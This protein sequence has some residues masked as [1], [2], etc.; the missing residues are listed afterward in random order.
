MEK[1][2]KIL[3]E[4][5]EL[6]KVVAEL[7]REA[8][9]EAALE[10]VRARGLAMHHSSELHGVINTVAGQFLNLNIDISG[11]AFICIN[12]EIDNKIIVYGAG[13]TADYA[14]KVTVPFFDRP[15]YTDII[16]RVKNGPG[17]FTEEF[18]KKEKIDFFKHMFKYPPYNQ[19][20]EEHRKKVLAREGGYTRACTVNQHTTIFMVN[21]HGRHFSEADNNI[22]I[23]FGK[24]FEQTYTR[25]LDLQKAETQAREA[26][27]EAALERIRTKTMAMQKSDELRATS[28]LLFNELK[29]L[30]KISTQIS[31]GIFDEEN[32]VLKLYATH[33]GKQ[34]EESSNIDLDEPHAMQKIYGGWKKKKPSIQIDL[35]GEELKAY[36]RF[37]SKY[38]DLKFPDERWVIHCAY[39]SRGVFSFSTTTPH[40]KQTMQLLERFAQVFDGTYTRFLDLQKAEEQAREAQI[41]AALERVRAASMAMHKTDELANVV[42][43]VAQ[44]FQE[45]GIDILFVYVGIYIYSLK[46]KYVDQ[47]FSPLK[48]IKEEPFYIKLPSE[49]WENTTIKDWSDGKEMGYVSVHG[50]EA[51]MQYAQAVDAMAN[52]NV[53]E[54]V[55]K[56]LS[57][58]IF[59][60][61]EANHKY[62]NLS[63]VQQRKATPAEI[64]ILKRFAKVFE[65][66]YTRF[67]DLQKAEEQAREAQIEA[68]L[69]RVRAKT[70]AMHKS[71]DLRSAIAVVF[72]Q[73]KNLG[74]DASSCSF[75][76]FNENDRSFVQW[77]S[78][79]KNEIYPA[80]L[81]VPYFDHPYYNFQLEGWKSGQPYMEFEMT[82]SLKDSYGSFIYDNSDFKTLKEETKEY[83]AS[84]DGWIMCNAFMSHGAIELI[85]EKSL[86]KKD[87]DI[88]K[89]FAAVF[90]QTYTRF[91]DL[92]KAEAQAREAQ[93]EAGLERVR[94]KT[95]A[96]HKSDE[97]RSVITVVF[98]QL[99][100]LGLEAEACS[101]IIYNKESGDA[102]HWFSGFGKEMYPESYHVQYFD[103]PFWNAQLDGWKEG[104][105]YKNFSFGGELQKEYNEY[106]FNHTELKNLPQEVKE[107]VNN[108]GAVVT[109]DAFMS[110]GMI[111]MIGKE[112]IS[113]SKALV[114]QR[115]AKV[116]DQTY[117]RFLDI[118]KAEAQT[119]EA[120]IE[121]ALERVRARTMAM[122]I[123]NEL[124]EA[125]SVLFQQLT[126]LGIE[127]AVCG[128]TILNRENY[129][130]DLYFST[131]GKVFSQKTSFPHGLT[132][133]TNKIYDNWVSGNDFY[134]TVMEGK[135]QELENQKLDAYWQSQGVEL[136]EDLTDFFDEHG[137][138]EMRKK[139]VVH[140]AYFSQGYL[141][142]SH[143]QHVEEVEVLKRFAKVFDQTY[144]RFLDLQK[145][146]AQ[147]REAQIEAALER[148]RAATMAMHESKELAHVAQILFEQLASLDVPLRWSWFSIMHE[149]DK[150]IETWYTEADGQFNDTPM[151]Q[152]IDDYHNGKRLLKEWKAGKPFH[153]NDM[154]GE[155]LKS[156][157]KEISKD[158]KFK[159]GPS[160]LIFKKN[161]GGTYFQTQSNFKYGLIGYG[162]FETRREE[163]LDLLH[164]FAKVFDQTY[165]RFLDLKKAEEQAREA[166]IEASLERVRSQSMA[167]QTSH[168]L[169]K[170]AEIVFN[171][172][173]RLSISTMRCGIGIIDK[174]SRRVD[175]WTTTITPSD[176]LQQVVGDEILIGHP[177]LEGI[178]ESWLKQETFYY[179]LKGADLKQYYQ[180]VANT[181]FHLPESIVANIQKG[182]EHH[183][184]C[185]V[186]PAGGLYAFRESPFSEEATQIMQ[187]F[188][189]SFHM[190][191]TRFLDL[192]RA[193]EQAQKI[194]LVNQENERLL[195]SI[196]PEQIAE[197]IRTG[198]QNV[199]KKFE[200][201]SIL[202]A[203]IV[204]FTIL[205]E[206]IAPQKVVGI[207]NGLFSK[208]DDLTDQFNLEKIKTIGD[209]YMVAA[210]VPEE[211][212]NHAQLIFSFAQN[213]LQTLK[214]YNQLM[215]SDLNL[216]IGIS[217]GPVVAGVIGKK[218]F[219]YDLWGDTVNTA[220]R[221][222]AYGQAGKIQI[223]PASFE[224]L[225]NDFAFEEIKNVEIKGKGIMDVYLWKPL[226]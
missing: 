40:D 198:Q 224:L 187:R 167:M 51:I 99:Q 84:L 208:F 181:N 28:L 22:L 117:T 62:G 34:W 110:H 118:Q 13:N 147:A 225:K 151:M 174:E 24:V 17:F 162:S 176:K 42:T 70:M 200:Q 204:G 184:Q 55:V 166:E 175:M 222:E 3:L 39:F 161:L 63:I 69:E 77:L 124:P 41:E 21:H 193:E 221:M 163:D 12:A 144:T 197:Q 48:G 108:F 116:F 94:A 122:H 113:E 192:Q 132:E 196:L 14:Q 29:G 27:I 214:E 153:T 149:K 15:I 11:G 172:L 102:T 75:I 111:E 145:A 164:R 50:A 16:N 127:P 95:M 179:V 205:S 58:E 87:I 213:M 98:E 4:N 138:A 32:Q 89:R 152:P 170:V 101:L 212:E 85:G 133:N 180:V 219:A 226:K 56:E 76:I 91:L 35:S 65:Q 45:L 19:T 30:G 8:E 130:G 136:F 211:K 25:F 52:W 82:K 182:T 210:G 185:V 72:E 9:I 49:P 37:R 207:L 115:F 157:F 173:D 217:S 33:H 53:F 150:V 195:H 105:L 141:H 201:V 59:E 79:F 97:L 148:V 43:V 191:Y 218:K 129:K 107:S 202:F 7:Q 215:G 156:Y 177:L 78:G 31:I 81:H 126:A 189:N 18:S 203:D 57:P 142:F 60:Q 155:E 6:K 158:P 168:D 134:I 178:Y 160:F 159:K 121:T 206:K 71:D 86:S 154:K 46:E 123:S 92:Q 83:I 139:Q 10:Q 67:L 120:Q 131:K 61:T 186:Y 114:L 5:E 165:T 54:R 20:S 106:I 223:S 26:Q 90:D 96:M 140:Y 199:V 38:S 100:L 143:F 47:W 68:A 104:I 183:Y 112:A 1:N 169:G 93:I 135:E 125:A 74:F 171:E 119:R 64:A 66:T 73:L 209:A 128:F 44:Q 88:L 80:G 188:A 109:S 36:N 216:R 103:H 146:E 220:A 2:E 194:K 137:I 190:A 23:R